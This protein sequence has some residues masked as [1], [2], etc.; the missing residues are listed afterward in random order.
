MRHSETMRAVSRLLLSHPIVCLLAALAA[1][2][3]LGV[4][5]PLNVV[6]AAD[7]TIQGE[8]FDPPASGTNIISGAG[9][10]GGA[11]LKFTDNVAASHQP[12]TC[13]TP[14]DVVLMASGGQSGGQ[15]S[16]SVNG[17]T[18]QALV[19]TNTTPYTFH[20][21]AGATTISV[22][23]GGTGTGHNAI[24]D[25]VTYS[26]SD[27]GTD[28]TPP[29][30]TITNPIVSG[31]TAS[32][33]LTSSEPGSTFQCKLVGF[34][35]ARID[36]CP[37]TKAYSGLTVGTT[38]TFKVWARDA[39]GNIDPTPA[40]FT[41]TPS[42]GTTPPP[43][44]TA[45]F[46][47]AGDIATGG[48]QND[49]LT[50]NLIKQLRVEHPDLRV[51]TAGDNAYQDGTLAQFNN[52]YHPVWGSFKDITSPTPGN[53]DWHTPQAQ[54]YRDYFGTV[55]NLRSVNPTWYAYNLGA[56]RVYAL[57]SEST[58]A[59][60]SSQ[61]N[62][63]QQDLLAN[64]RPC[65]LA[66]WHHPVI[67]SGMHGNS[68]NARPMFELMDKP[69]YDVDLVLNGHDHNYE[70]FGNIT[71]DPNNGDF[72]A[73]PA[74]IREIVVGTGG[75][76]LRSMPTTQTGSEKRLSSTHGVLHLTLEET[77]YTGEFRATS[78]SIADSFSGSCG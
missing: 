72:K 67:S 14:C 41:F 6:R 18:P 30:T 44:T 71:I 4:L 12:V 61:Y 39:A 65:M 22:K 17:S 58:M 25:V 34:D 26:A 63:V 46:A 77:R 20:L 29:Q 57:D 70:R 19:S 37:L 35:P 42:D 76:N 13:S 43:G 50:G 36:P 31:T 33:E 73:D 21:A 23:A 54:G 48:G 51:F 62:F 10:S 66:Y 68:P 11:A 53:H 8:S 52:Y 5:G 38:Y 47:G 49:T 7:V 2:V 15:A 75:A 9:Y 45:H 55:T 59:I 60:G 32:F 64:S 16:F 78:G 28:T 56:W 1:A 3:V 69:E 74:G 27:G 24:L 40:T